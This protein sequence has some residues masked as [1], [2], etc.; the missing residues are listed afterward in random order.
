MTNTSS[1]DWM[2]VVT[3]APS[4]QGR[5]GPGGYGEPQPKAS[6]LVGQEKPSMAIRSD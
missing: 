3:T 5:H 1:R 6:W 4:A 2:K